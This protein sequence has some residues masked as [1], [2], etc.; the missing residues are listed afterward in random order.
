[1]FSDNNFNRLVKTVYKPPLGVKNET[2]NIDGSASFLS[3]D[4]SNTSVHY[5]GKQ[6]KKLQ[7]MLAG[8]IGIRNERNGS[9][10]IYLN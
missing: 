3:Q 6:W 10:K 2:F 5:G 1:M 7:V 8:G 9:G 4:C